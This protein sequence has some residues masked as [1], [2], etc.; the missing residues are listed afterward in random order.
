MRK[1]WPKSLEEV[2]KMVLSNI[3]DEYKK[4]IK[5]SKKRDLTM[6]QASLGM[7]I[8]NDFGLWKGN[9]ELLISCRTL[10]PDDASMIIIAAIWRVLRNEGNTR[11]QPIKSKRHQ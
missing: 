1:R 7:R 10:N 2:I 8:R 11:K 6:F 4:E 9:N 5:D 3:S